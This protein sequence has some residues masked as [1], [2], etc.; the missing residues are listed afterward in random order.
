MLLYFFS[1]QLLR[2]DLLWNLELTAQLDWLANK[3]QGCLLSLLPHFWD[4]RYA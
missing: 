1:L 4:S 3:A 2:Q